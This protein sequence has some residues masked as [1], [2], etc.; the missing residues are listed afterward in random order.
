MLFKLLILCLT[1]AF[2]QPCSITQTSL[3]TCVLHNYD[4]SNRG[5]VSPRQLYTAIKTKTS[6]FTRAMIIAVEGP[7]YR[8]L[9]R[10]CD[11]NRDNCL[12]LQEMQGC[13]KS[14]LWKQTAYSLLCKK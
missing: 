13:P 10:E 8:R 6:S 9:F 5:C 3:W 2:A 11:S 1:I 7:K 4:Y 12:S 14:C